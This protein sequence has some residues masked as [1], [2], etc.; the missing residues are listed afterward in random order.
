MSVKRA[1]DTINKRFELLELSDDVLSLLGRRIG[2]LP[3]LALVSQRFHGLFAKSLQALKPLASRPFGIPFRSMENLVAFRRFANG[4]TDGI[5]EEHMSTFS[6]AVSKGALPNLKQLWLG[7][8]KIGDTGMAALADAVST[9]A[10]AHLTHLELWGNQIGDVGMSTFSRAVS[11]GA[12]ASLG[13]L[14]VDDGP[15]GTEHP[16]LTAA[17]EARGIR[18][19]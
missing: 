11:K 16:A 17:C 5:S 15:L 7:R 6:R 4:I 10:L 1:N 13:M 19:L 9:G 12:L 18:L 14:I 2:I 3:K 8:N